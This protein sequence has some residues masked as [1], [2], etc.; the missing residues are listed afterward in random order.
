ME[1][2]KDA[3]IAIPRWPL[4]N[5]TVFR[6]FP[7]SWMLMMGEILKIQAITICKNSGSLASEVTAVGP[8]TE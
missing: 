6:I 1:N 3:S 7:F 5:L 8:P 2:K 4:K